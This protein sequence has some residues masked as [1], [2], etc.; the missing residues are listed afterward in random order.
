MADIRKG[1]LLTVYM[2]KPQLMT[3]CT[4]VIHPVRRGPR[5]NPARDINRYP[6]TMRDMP[7]TRVR[8]YPALRAQLPAIGL[9]RA[10]LSKPTALK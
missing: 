8:R 7:T 1:L 5:K 6:M 3:T 2:A 4:A 10:K 9:K